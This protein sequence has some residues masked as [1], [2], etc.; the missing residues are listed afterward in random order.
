MDLLTTAQRPTEALLDL[1]TQMCAASERL[2]GD[3]E[4][5]RLDTQRL[6]AQTRALVHRLQSVRDIRYS[7]DR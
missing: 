7:L 2:C 5:L 6:I 4:V 3:S 1:A